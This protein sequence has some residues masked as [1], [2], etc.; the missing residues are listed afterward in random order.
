MRE[1]SYWKVAI[2]LVFDTTAMYL[3]VTSMKPR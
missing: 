2:L 1:R 3:S